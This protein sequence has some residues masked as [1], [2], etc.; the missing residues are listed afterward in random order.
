MWHPALSQPPPSGGFITGSATGGGSREAE[1]SDEGS[2]VTIV[3]AALAFP[4]SR[5]ELGSR[6]MW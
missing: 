1:I 5:T 6:G 3:A 2:A 4:G